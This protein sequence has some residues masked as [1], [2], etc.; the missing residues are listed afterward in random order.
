MSLFNNNQK[1]QELFPSKKLFVTDNVEM[2]GIAK[3]VSALLNNNGGI[4]I[5]EFLNVLVPIDPYV[6]VLEQQL[7]QSLQPLPPLMVEADVLFQQKCVLIHV[8]MGF[9]GPY[10][11]QRTLYSFNELD[12]FKVSAQELPA[13]I[14]KKNELERRWDHEWLP[15]EIQFSLQNEVLDKLKNNLQQMQLLSDD[16]IRNKP[17]QQYLEIFNESNQIS[18]AAFWLLGNNLPCLKLNVIDKSNEEEAI[19]VFTTQNSIVP[20]LNELQSF[21]NEMQFK[22]ENVDNLRNYVDEEPEFL[23]HYILHVVINIILHH[24]A[25]KQ[26]LEITISIEK[27]HLAAQLN[28]QKSLNTAIYS[29]LTD[30]PHAS[31]HTVHIAQ[32]LYYYYYPSLQRFYA[33]CL[34]LDNF[35]FVSPIFAASPN[36][37]ALNNISATYQVPLSAADLI[38]NVDNND[39]NNDIVNNENKD[40]KDSK[41]VQESALI[42]AFLSDS[43]NESITY[44]T[45]SLDNLSEVAIELHN[46]DIIIDKL[47]ESNHHSSDDN[48]SISDTKTDEQTFQDLGQ[49]SPA[50]DTASTTPSAP[51]KSFKKST[52]SNFLIDNVNDNSNEVSNES[53]Y[54]VAKAIVY[55]DVHDN[56]SNGVKQEMIKIVVY[57]HSNPGTMSYD[58]V[59]ALGRPKPTVD[60]YIANLKEKNIIEFKGAPKSG[61]YFLTKKI[62]KLLQKAPKA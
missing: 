50:F 9:N 27:D 51:K 11:Y 38:E 34:L 59:A 39:I 12:V 18:V 41:N 44:S 24:I 21:L 8:P 48:L 7:L 40:Y 10:V 28:S 53:L 3:Y 19:K 52:V 26:P 46:N 15:S 55:Q 16:V 20:A 33:K 36:I 4:I 42:N 37:L 30:W 13:F 23:K 22:L 56:L 32:L 29:S 2:D 25:D 49:S 1:Y 45:D 57:L 58:I 43:V 5:I 35:S 6:K 17:W 54:T 47:N 31:V 60:R 61:G 62:S 14:H